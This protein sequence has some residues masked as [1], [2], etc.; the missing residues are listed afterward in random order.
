MAG[1]TPNRSAYPQIRFDGGARYGSNGC[2]LLRFPLTPGAA[3][4]KVEAWFIPRQQ[5]PRVQ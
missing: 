4:R 1:R 3:F 5:A 2:S